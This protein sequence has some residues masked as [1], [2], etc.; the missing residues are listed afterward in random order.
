MN[1]E[2]RGSIFLKDGRYYWKVRLPGESNRKTIPLSRP[3]E[4]ATNNQKLAKELAKRKWAQAL[5]SLNGATSIQT[6]GHLAVA[7]KEHVKVHYPKSS[8]M[9]ARIAYALDLLDA[10]QNEPVNEFGP[11]KLQQVREQMIGK[12]L[13]VK[14]VN[15]RTQFIRKMFK[16]AVGRE[17][18]SPEIAYALEQVENLTGREQGVNESTSHTPVPVEVVKK[19]LP[20]LGQTLQ[21]MVKIQLYGAMRP[22]ELLRMRPCDVVTDGRYWI[23]NVPKERSKNQARTKEFIRRIPLSVKIQNI[24]VPYLMGTSRNDTFFKYTSASYRR[25]VTRACD[26]VFGEKSEKHWTPYQLR[27]T[28]GTYI[29]SRLGDDGL[30]ASQ[31]MLGHKHA[32][33]TEI[34][35]RVNTEAATKAAEELMTIE[36]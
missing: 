11:L 26:R 5:A 33:T 6:I 13:S 32:D 2:Y 19:T 17:I 18:V 29:R 10:V 9:P 22:S 31:A 35:A 4:P 28:A 1:Q 16:W 8:D 30:T 23:Y 24:L 27:H 20:E 36:L 12:D 3:G 25:A 21:D 15:E 7:Y 14:I 34:Y